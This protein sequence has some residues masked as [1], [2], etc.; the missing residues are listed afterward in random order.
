MNLTGILAAVVFAAIH[1]ISPKF[2]VKFISIRQ[3]TS[4]IAGISI[5]YVFF[6]LI[7]RAI[8]NERHL[9]ETFS[10]SGEK[11]SY[12]LYGSMLLGLVIVYILEQVLER[13]ESKLEDGGSDSNI[14]I[15]WAHIGT[16]IFYNFVIGFLLVEQEFQQGLSPFIYVGVIG[17]HFLTNDWVLREHFADEFKHHGRLLLVGAVLI[18]LI[19][20]LLIPANH[21]MLGL[22][23][24]AVA[25]GL[26]LNTIKDELPTFKEDKISAF[27]A[28][29]V[30]YSALLLII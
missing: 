13:T 4:F 2:H 30:I 10:L 19:F 7:P 15:F 22:L 21:V 26:I 17:L 6:H 27:L 11:A 29:V 1:F 23:E 24:A 5:A 28:G 8:E 9:T 16:Y 12:I 20:G 25:G 3:L 18:G 14:G